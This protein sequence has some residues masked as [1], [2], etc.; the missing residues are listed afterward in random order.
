MNKNRKYKKSYREMAKEAGVS[1]G[2]IHKASKVAELGRSQEVIDG[3]KTADEILREEGLMPQ[4]PKKKT[5]LDRCVEIL[6]KLTDDDL[7][8]LIKAVLD[9]IESR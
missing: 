6:P 5:H 3:I 8:T 7:A 4:K 1:V 9:E 2:V